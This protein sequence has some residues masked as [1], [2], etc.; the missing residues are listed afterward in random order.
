MIKG[1]CTYEGIR[2]AKATMGSGTAMAKGNR[3]HN[4]ASNS[5]TGNADVVIGASKGGLSSYGLT[6]LVASLFLHHM[7][8]TST[9][10]CRNG[11]NKAAQGGRPLCSIRDPL[12]AL[13]VFLDFYHNFDWSKYCISTYGVVPLEH[14]NVMEPLTPQRKFQ[15]KLATALRDRALDGTLVERC[16]GK[17]KYAQS[18]KLRYLQNFLLELVTLLTRLTMQTTWAAAS[19]CNLSSFLR[20]CSKTGTGA[21]WKFYLRRINIVNLL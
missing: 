12:D 14:G 1:W 16:S 8:P 10:S 11:S 4:T 9:A 19:T 13:I 15:Y 21:L 17:N 2:F 5:D 7:N 6:V 3:N 20:I 18:K